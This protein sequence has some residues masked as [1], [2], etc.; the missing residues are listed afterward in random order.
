MDAAALIRPAFR[1]LFPDPVNDML[2]RAQGH[3]MAGAYESAVLALMPN[4]ATFTGGRMGDGSV[5]A[6]VVLGA[7]AAAHSREARWLAMAWLAALLR[8]T[9]VLLETS[10]QE[11]SVT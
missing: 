8:A 4:S 6:Q 7:D 9:A 2:S 3:A 11:R 1:R 5:I 10:E